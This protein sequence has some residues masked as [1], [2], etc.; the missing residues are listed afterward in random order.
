VRLQITDILA[1]LPTATTRP[2]DSA[3]RLVVPALAAFASACGGG[4]SDGAAPPQLVLAGPGVAAI[5]EAGGLPAGYNLV[6]SDEFD[7]D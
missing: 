2:G 7:V 3:L 5:S 4:S 6:W 1:R